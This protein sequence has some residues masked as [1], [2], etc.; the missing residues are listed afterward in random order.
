L[1]STSAAAP[2]SDAAY[3]ALGEVRAQIQEGTNP[4][5]PMQIRNAPTRAMKE[6]GYGKGYQHAHQFEDAVTDM[7]CL[8]EEL[9]GRNFTNQLNVVLK[10]V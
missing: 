1:R 9:K 5:V 4:P 6:W 7:E 3:K 10:S 2:K 8:P